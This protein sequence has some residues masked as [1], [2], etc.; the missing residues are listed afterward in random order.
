MKQISDRVVACCGGNMAKGSAPYSPAFFGETLYEE[1]R[2][3]K[4][5]FD[6]NNRLN[7]GKICAP[8]NED[9]P[10]MKVDTIKRG[11]FDRQIPSR[12]AHQ[13][14]ARWRATAIAYASTLT[15]T[16]RCAHQ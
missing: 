8:M 1:L 11:T 6:L 9:A 2:R 13:C 14:A 7:P 5:V 16:A 4:A 10:L 3:I 15:C 12:S